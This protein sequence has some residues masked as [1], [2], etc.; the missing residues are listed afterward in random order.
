[1]KDLIAPRLLR[2][3]AAAAYLSIS[4]AAL[5]Q[6]RASGEITVVRMPGRLGVATRVPLFDRA[7]LD[8]AIERWK[9]GAA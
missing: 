6:L 3:E 4:V 9:G 8:L 5:D 1:V 7:D 2:R